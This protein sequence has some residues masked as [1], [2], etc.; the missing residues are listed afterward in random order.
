V[1]GWRNSPVPSGETLHGVQGAPGSNPGTPTSQ[2]PFV[3]SPFLCEVTVSR[4]NVILTWDDQE[5][6]WVTYVPSLNWLS[7]YGE[8]REEALEMT[9]EAVTG[10]IEAAQQEGIDLPSGDVTAE[11]TSVD[12]SVA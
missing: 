11:V 6:L 12:V 9:R 10:Y 5:Q 2:P 4:Y 3:Q 7:T 8:S 1:E